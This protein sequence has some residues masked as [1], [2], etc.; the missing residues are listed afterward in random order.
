MINDQYNG[1]NF[2]NIKN[3]KHNVRSTNGNAMKGWL[4]IETI[5]D[6]EHHGENDNLRE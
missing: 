4:R 3:R 5:N 6:R 2:L 1:L